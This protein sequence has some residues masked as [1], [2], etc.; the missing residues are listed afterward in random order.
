M[1]AHSVPPGYRR[2]EPAKRP[3]LG[4]FTSIIDCILEDDQTVHRKQQHTAKRT[5]DHLR[6][7][8]GFEG[9]ET[10]VKDYVRERRRHFR[11]MFVPLVHPPG[12][13]QADFGKAEVFIAGV[14]RKAHFLATHVP[15]H[16]D[17]CFVKAY[18]VRDDGSRV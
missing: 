10:I 1:L 5:F 3:N 4:P 14:E 11:E 7:E 15:I 9:G 6:D 17:K 16:I 2:R 12:H 13:A 8:H 18:P